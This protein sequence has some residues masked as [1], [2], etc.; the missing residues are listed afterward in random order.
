[1]GRQP[2]LQHLTAALSAAI[3]ARG[4]TVLVGG[5]PGIGKSRLV[6]EFAAVAR[7]RGVTVLAGR[8][9]DLVGSGI[10]FLPLVEA[11]RGLPGG[12]APPPDELRAFFERAAREACVALVLEDVHWADESTLDL[13][14]VL[15]HSFAQSRAMIIA[16]YR[17]RPPDR[18][19]TVVSE[20]LRSR[21]ASA[22][23]LGPLPPAEVEAL[24]ESIAG[25]LLPTDVTGPIVVRSEGNPFHA[26]ELYAAARRGEQALPRAVGDA[27]LQRLTRLGV[28]ARSVV[29]VAS[30][31]GGDVPFGLLAAV[32][33]LPESDLVAALRDAVEHDILVPDRAAGTY[34]FRHALL[35]EAVYATLLP[36]ECEA[37]HTAL[38]RALAAA[39]APTGS[40]ASELAR[41]WAAAGQPVEAIRESMRAAD[42]AEAVSGRA[43]AL[44]HL[45]R[46]LMLWPAAP[47]TDRPDRVA[48][49]TRAA[50]LAHVTGRG[51]RAVELVRE[52]IAV[53]GGSAAMYERLG[54]YLLP[55]GERDA[56]LAALRH[57]ADLAQ[58]TPPSSDRVEVLTSF[59]NALRL[60]A[61]FASARTVCE[62]AID[63][64][65]ALGD[66]RLADRARDI[67]GL[68]LCYLGAPADGLDI[69]RGACRDA[70]TRRTPLDIL[71]PF[72]LH[73][74]ALM[75]LGRVG[76]AAEV[77]RQGL[78][79]ARELGAE[80]GVGTL[81]AA[82]LAEARLCL[83]DWTGA[84]EL[85]SAALRSSGAFWPHQLHRVRA[86]LAIGRGDLDAARHHLSLGR[87]AGQ[88]P[89]SAPSYAGLVAEL[90]LWAGQPD[91]AAH[92]VDAG[93][94]ADP[95]D[96]VFLRT[97]LSALGLR[98]E[99]ERAAFAHA[100][101]DPAAAGS[102]RERATRLVALA[103]T[104]AAP[105]TDARLWGAVAEA[106]FSREPEHWQAAVAAAADRPAVAAYCH[107]QHAVA[108]LAA[109]AARPL[110]TAAARS[111]HHIATDLDAVPLRREVVLL[112]ER[113]RLDLVGVRAAQPPERRGLLG[114]TA[115]EDEVL[116][117]LAR[118]Y[119]NAEIAAELAI[120]VKTA[121]VHVTNI[122]R[123][124]GAARRTDAA[125]IAQ[126]LD[127]TPRRPG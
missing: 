90:E 61:Q 56:G 80:R 100:T 97:R 124:L 70:R 110:V 123:K 25:A 7:A 34:R 118:G 126:R 113:A 14:A 44:Q 122:L 21:V 35:A 72:V 74:D 127:A 91:R 8:C 111:A 43:E 96:H 47:A 19:A 15:A 30:A 82:N 103:R 81:L 63:A 31:A 119:T 59:A 78:P 40:T 13:L 108:L 2:A 88:E 98:A 105:S 38:A 69:L 52:A 89:P 17:H 112:A 11:A 76:E 117:L 84:E 73:S 53:T 3:A 83:G 125:A 32:C 109:G 45:E 101:G 37:V 28:P 50:E 106:E 42:H 67:R 68:S 5:E 60:S 65:D 51:A 99:A 95:D 39:A 104:G 12:S 41:H 36:G 48:V 18:V 62:E 29:R 4:S 107:W 9:L 6:A 58:S 75:A 120:S 46:V 55:V 49:L 64:A 77:A 114:L 92:A 71:C 27:L 20:L 26:E 33:Q 116:S 94:T 1:V 22:V 86:Q 121:S 23:D 10:S 66:P 93:L 87:Q 79:L 24:L 115:R 16:T 57:A 54:S 85:L 102:A